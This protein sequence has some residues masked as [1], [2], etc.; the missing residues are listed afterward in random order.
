[1]ESQITLF[2]FFSEFVNLFPFAMP[3]TED[4]I[5]LFLEVLKCLIFVPPLKSGNMEISLSINRISDLTPTDP[6]LYKWIWIYIQ[7]IFYV[8][9]NTYSYIIC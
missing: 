6:S 8:I 9:Y 3:P 5:E 2:H 7:Y 4:E 1:M